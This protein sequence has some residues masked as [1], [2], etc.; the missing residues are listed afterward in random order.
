MKAQILDGICHAV[1]LDVNMIIDVQA[2]L[3][4]LSLVNS[5]GILVGGG[6]H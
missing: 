1:K 5:L 4:V 3:K 6:Q 2:G